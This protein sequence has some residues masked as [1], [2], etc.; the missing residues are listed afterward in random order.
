MKEAHILLV[1]DTEINRLVIRQ[2]LEKWWSLSF[3][4]AS[5][6]PEAVELARRENFNLIFMDVR[7]PGMDGYDTT[8]EI[9][10]LPGYSDVRIIALTADV[11]KKVS[12]EMHKGLFD[13]VMIKPVE[14]DELLAKIISN[15]E[16][17]PYKVP[18]NPG[19]SNEEALY[20]L[21]KIHEYMDYKTS[22]VKKF[23]QKMITEIDGIKDQF[24]AAIDERDV[25][26]FDEHYHK[27]KWIFNLLEMH[28]INQHFI[29]AFNLL[30]T[31]A[32]DDELDK[33]KEKGASM[34][35]LAKKGLEKSE[36]EMEW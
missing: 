8:R 16:R 6:G 3:K 4:E 32:K 10:K 19:H 26:A 21:K 20:G 31:K 7:M 9:R 22:A 1:E 35:E 34:L 12:E 17:K 28:K 36:K 11:S 23:L 33:A 30:K 24:I 5:S 29:Y 27:C 14:P 18:D 2:L 25:Q 13:D 15:V